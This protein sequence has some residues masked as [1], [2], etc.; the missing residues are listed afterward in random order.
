M[1]SVIKIGIL[2]FTLNASVSAL[3]I[4]DHASFGGVTM[5]QV[6]ALVSIVKQSGYSCSSI[7]GAFPF[8]LSHGFTLKCNNFRYTYEI[9]DAGG[10]WKVTVK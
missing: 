5:D 7:S 8:L 3:T 2:F 9:E 6:K 1:K 4:E 10:Q